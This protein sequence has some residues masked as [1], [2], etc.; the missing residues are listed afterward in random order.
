MQILVVGAGFS[1]AVIARELAEHGFDIHVIDKRNHVGGNA[2]DFINE[3]GI[4]V[5]QYGPHLFHTSNRVVVE[6]LS[7]FTAWIPYRHRVKAMLPDGRLVAFPVNAE[8]AAVVGKENILDIFFRPYSRKMWGVELE[9][10]DPQILSRV[11]VR[12]DLNEDYFPNDDFQAMPANGYSA[13]FDNILNHPRISVRLET[14]F[15]RQMEQRY[16][17]TFN[18]MPIDEYFDFCFGELPYRSIKFHTHTI[19]IPQLFPVATVNFTHSGPFTR[20]TEWK[21]IAPCAGDAHFTTITVEEPCDYRE[22]NFERF[23][24]VK[25]IL[26]RNR[27]IYARYSN[28]RPAHVTFIGRCGLYAY[29]D[30]HQAVLSALAT[31]R[32]FLAIC[33]N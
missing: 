33:T 3:Y 31:A 20:V 25:D 17:H 19:P 26:G 5:H 24:P 27:K 13:L 32:S 6:W 30:M 8:T 14:P 4:R 7:R 29:L 18:S 23:Y 28:S 10:L 21:N 1:G 16:H 11:P 22:N 15:E 2:W 12:E 9:S